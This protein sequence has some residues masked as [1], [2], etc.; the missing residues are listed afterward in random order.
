MTGVLVMPE[1][2]MFPHGNA[3]PGTDVPT[4]VDHRTFPLV[5]SSE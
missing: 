3:L 5:A 1:G 2:S 4:V